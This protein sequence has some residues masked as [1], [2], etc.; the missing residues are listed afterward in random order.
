MMFSI[1]SREKIQSECADHTEAEFLKRSIKQWNNLSANE[2]HKYTEKA[3]D[4]QQLYKKLL[5]QAK[6]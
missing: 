6:K 3:M 5:L 2:Q 1:E 4:G